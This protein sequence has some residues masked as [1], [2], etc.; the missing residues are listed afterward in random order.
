[1]QG[2][3]TIPWGA[4]KHHA[5]LPKVEGRPFLDFYNVRYTSRR[6]LLALLPRLLRCGGFVRLLGCF[7]RARESLETRKD[8]PERKQRSSGC[9]LK[10]RDPRSLGVGIG[11]RKTARPRYRVEGRVYIIAMANEDACRNHR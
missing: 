7:C 9:C 8:D 1:V 5:S 3:V 11:H 2:R 6:L 10:C 4:A